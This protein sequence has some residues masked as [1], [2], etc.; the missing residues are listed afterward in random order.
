[1][2]KHMRILVTGASGQLGNDLMIELAGRGHEVTGVSSQEMDL[3]DPEAVR[4]YLFSIHPDAVMHCAAYTAVDMAEDDADTCLAV[5]HK[6]TEAVANVCADIGC[7]LLYISTDY[8]FSG[9]G[10]RP[11]EPDDAVEPLNL[12]GKSK[13]LGEQAVRAATDRHFIVRTSWVFGSSGKNFVKTMLRLG[14]EREQITV[15]NDQFGSPTY[16]K[17]LSVLLAEMIVTDK[18]GTY[19]A[20]NEGVCSWYDFACAIMELAELTC[21]VLP[22]SSGQYPSRA[23]RP[24]NSRMSKE[25]LTENGFQRLP[26]WDDALRRCLGELKEN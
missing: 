2:N 16:T 21:R 9:D 5:N 23:K 26:E 24:V 12:Y 25:K 22:V 20:T 13:L 8:V 10:E 1:M 15:V 4:R 11:W 19:H 3:T 14:T 6:G 7:K 17:D 18:Y